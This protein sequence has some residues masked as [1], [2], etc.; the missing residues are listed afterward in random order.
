METGFV[1][2]THVEDADGLNFVEMLR[3]LTPQQ[4]GAGRK[5]SED[6]LHRRVPIECVMRR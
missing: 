3:P 4:L 5:K 1:V 6:P 2:L